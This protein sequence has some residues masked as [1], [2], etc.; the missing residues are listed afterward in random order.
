MATW[1][2]EP[3]LRDDPSR[4]VQFPIKYPDIWKMYK[5]HQSTDWN[6]EEIELSNDIV[7]WNNHLTDNERH[8][9]KLITAFFAVSDG[10][11]LENLIVRI[12]N[13]VKISEA[14]N[15]YGIQLK[16]EN[17]HAEVYGQF[18][19][20][21]IRDPKEQETL[22]NALNNFASIKAKSDWALKWVA[23]KTAPFVQ[24]IVAFAVVEGVFFS[25][26]FCVPYWLQSR[27]LMLNFAQ[28]NEFIARDEGM[29]T[30]FACLICNHCENKL[31]EE[32]VHEM[33]K[34]AV[35]V[36]H[37]FIDEAI[38][39]DLKGLNKKDTKEY[40]EYVADRLLDQLGFNKIW[41]SNNP[42]P[43][44]AAIGMEDKTNFFEHKA[45]QYQKNTRI[46]SDDDEDPFDFIND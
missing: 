22:F 28:A 3:I 20:T 36:E 46:E 27:G 33:F 4:F 38:P 8:T 17:T 19:N 29:H 12:M 6:P 41:N 15:F 31:P 21:Y 30:D 39:V 24:R 25:S 32:V 7:H 42:Y 40:V 37:Q 23:S 26:S 14:R 45:T 11:V 9:V 44:M 10:I 34:D 1:K 2:D 5:L 16:I 35:R 13:E 18:I 43:F